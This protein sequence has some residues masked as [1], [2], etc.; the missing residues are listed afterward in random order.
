MIKLKIILLRCKSAGCYKNSY[1]GMAGFMGYTFGN[2]EIQEL[3]KNNISNPENVDWYRVVAE[4]IYND[5]KYY[6]GFKF[7]GGF[8]TEDAEDIAQDVQIAVI[9]NLVSYCSY[10]EEHGVSGNTWLVKIIENKVNDW[11]RKKKREKD[12]GVI[13]I[14]GLA[15]SGLVDTVLYGDNKTVK[16]ELSTE[17]IVVLKTEL[18]EVVTKVC[19]LRTSVDRKLA[20]FL[21]ILSKAERNS[22][23]GDVKSIEALFYGKAYFEIYGFL[24]AH[25]DG[26]LG[27]EAT[28]VIL[29]PVADIVMSCKDDIFLLK[30]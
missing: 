27:A 11:F 5:V 14:D 3:I 7:G 16:K 19:G 28:D 23:K 4:C 1:R 13:S 2:Q 6:L 9:R 26:L 10:A 17:E 8:S 12:I 30:K 22:E 29:K 18:Q 24:A 15:E 20:F 25:M 21:I